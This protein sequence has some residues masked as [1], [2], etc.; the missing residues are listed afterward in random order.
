MGG[1]KINNRNQG[2]R[3]P[4]LK[5]EVAVLITSEPPQDFLHAAG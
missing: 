1:G 2:W 3:V 4:G 5:L